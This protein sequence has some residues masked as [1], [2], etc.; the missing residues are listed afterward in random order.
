MNSLEN[1]VI[2]ITGA[3]MGWG[4]AAAIAAAKQNAQLSLVDYN[5]KALAAAK[6]CKR[7]PRH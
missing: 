5:E 4:L 2:A 6:P 1:R 7:K 3:G